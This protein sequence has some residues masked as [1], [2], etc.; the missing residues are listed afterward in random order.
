MDLKKQK[1]RKKL[2]D[3][4]KTKRGKTWFLEYFQEGLTTIDADFLPNLDASVGLFI[5][6]SLNCQFLIA[7]GVKVKSIVIDS[8]KRVQ[9][10]SGD[11]VSTIEMV[12]SQN[13]TLWLNGVTPALTVDKC[14]SPKIVLMQPCYD[15]EKQCE[16]LTSNVTAGNVELPPVGDA[17]GVVLPI[18][19]QFFF[20]VDK[21]TQTAKCE[22]MEHAG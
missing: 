10:Q 13:C 5:A 7:E 17:D 8:C 11:I 20:K 15:Q 18:P 16:I 19:E 14:D 22:V 12:N 9:V 2:P 1:Q 4:K 21:E 3:P 6:S